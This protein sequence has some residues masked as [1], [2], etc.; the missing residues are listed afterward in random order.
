MADHY[1]VGVIGR[2]GGGNYGHGLDVV[3]KNVEGVEIVAVADEDAAGREQ[4]VQRLGVSRGYADYREMLEKERPQLVSIAM[5][6]PDCHFDMIRACAAAGI[7]MFVEKP[8]CTTLAEAD[9]LIADCERAKVKVAVAQHVSYSLEW[10]RLVQMIADG[11][12]GDILELRGRG[13]EDHRGGGDDFTLLGSHI[14]D[15][16][17]RVLGDPQ[18]CF[19]RLLQDG[20]PVAR[21]DV[22][23]GG[24]RI[25]LTAG[26]RVDAVY[27][28]SGAPLAYFTSQRE[29]S[30]GARFGLQIFG[31]RGALSF[32]PGTPQRLFHLDDPR[33]HA[34]W[35]PVVCPPDDVARRY[36]EENWLYQANIRIARDL[37]ECIEQDKQPRCS[38]YDARHIMEMVMAAYESHRLG[39]PAPLPLAPRENPLAQL[40]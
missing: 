13:K 9:Q 10:Q 31:T 5:R 29:A 32:E 24:E 33:W 23:E 19:G 35:Q 12:I 39:A 26:N 40:A 18:W 34:E 38:I 4:A 22:R 25:G 14:V 2:T 1:R 27:G 17:R 3:W 28:F 20:E 21:S 6:W 30:N 7:H 37:I 11:A 8:L 36:P 15:A 16:F